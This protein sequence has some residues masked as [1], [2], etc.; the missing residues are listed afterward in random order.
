MWE[1]E[2]RMRKETIKIREQLI[3]N[4][5]EKKK[6]SLSMEDI[7]EIFGVSI[8]NVYRIIKKKSAKVDSRK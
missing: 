3:Y 5:W 1:N 8:G 6:N 7:K 2:Y 4:L